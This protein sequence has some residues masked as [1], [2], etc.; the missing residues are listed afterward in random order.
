[1]SEAGASVLVGEGAAAPVKT[2]HPVPA[3][4][5]AVIVDADEKWA[6][7]MEAANGSNQ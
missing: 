2:L 5:D 6:D 1:M 7:F 3:S 4:G